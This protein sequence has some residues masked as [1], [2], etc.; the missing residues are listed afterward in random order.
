MMTAEISGS[1]AT[2]EIGPFKLTD[3][4][5]VGYVEGTG[6]P[7]ESI[8]ESWNGTTWSAV[9][10]PR[11]A[12]A[13][14]ALVGVSCVT[15]AVCTAVGHTRTASGAAKTLVESWDGTAWS[16]VP[17]PN[18]AGAGIN[19]LNGVSCPSAT[20]CVAVGGYQGASTSPAKTLVESWDGTAW[21][22]DP[23]PSPGG[24]NSSS[25]LRGAS[26]PAVTTCLAV[27]D[28]GPPGVS[29]TLTE[30]GTSAAATQPR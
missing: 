19:G 4:T 20:M 22:I 1:S 29:K 26:C 12:S 28:D 6:G 25:G 16:I 15:T 18:A 2:G 8:I 14:N 27:G 7:D 3:C 11:V 23:S 30:M 5:A 13:D 21:S 10:H 24:A 9:P 17:S